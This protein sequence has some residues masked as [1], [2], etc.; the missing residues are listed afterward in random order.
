MVK[1][2]GEIISGIK[3]FIREQGG[4]LS[5]WYVGIT[6]EPKTRLQTHKVEDAWIYIRASSHIVAR[7]IEEYFI[8]LG[9]D[10]GPG[11]GDE[12]AE[13]VYAYKKK[14]YTEP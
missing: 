12:D 11:G 8:R 3:Q 4:S 13:Y 6:E 7:E 10:G 5:K 14:P 1:T 2:K 9:T